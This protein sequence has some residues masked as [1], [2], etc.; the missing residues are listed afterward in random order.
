MDDITVLVGLHHAL[1]FYGMPPCVNLKKDVIYEGTKYFLEKMSMPT[2]SFERGD[3]INGTHFQEVIIETF[4]LEGY[5]KL[6]TNYF[7][8]M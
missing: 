4:H 2:F 1:G 3:V 5:G 7:Y 6:S 8:V